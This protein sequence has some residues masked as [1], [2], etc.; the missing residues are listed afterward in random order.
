M[1]RALELAASATERTSPNPSVGAVIVVDGEIIAEGVTNP[2]PGPHAEAVA[3]RVAGDRARGAT[4][5]VSLEPCAHEGRTPACTEAIISAG[6]SEVHYALADPDPNVNG[7]G[8]EALEGAGIRTVVGEGEDDARRFYEAYVKHRTTGLPFVIAKFASSLDGRIAAASGDSRWVSG[9]GSRAWAHQ[10]RARI[11]AIL[12]GSST[13][14]IDDPQLTARPDEV[15]TERQPLRI[16]V[17]TRGR[18]PPMAR[19]FTGPARTL[20]ATGDAAP[21]EWRAAI[22]AR[23]VELLILPKHDD[24][25]DLRL[26]L[27]ELGRRG[28]VTLLVEGGGMILGNFF[29]R[30]LVDKIHAIIAPLIVGAQEAHAAIAGKGAYRMTDALRLSDLTVERL[31]D[32][33]LV[34]AYPVYEDSP[35]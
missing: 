5:Y 33:I 18:T 10:L 31:G 30:A 12:V 26:L 35:T 21:A 32:D 29:D 7:T 28:I 25:V 6:I 13:V 14:V 8:R 23:A 15:E 19:V 24:H 4:M 2:P 34:T 1:Q 27:E 11:D 16:V 9:P 17:D 20:V 3:L 22:E